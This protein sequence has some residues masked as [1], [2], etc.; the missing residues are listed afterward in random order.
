MEN[1]YKLTNMND[2]IPLSNIPIDVVI[3][4]EFNVYNIHFIEN[5]V[6]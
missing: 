3:L 4:L 5:W 1:K 2:N 6:S